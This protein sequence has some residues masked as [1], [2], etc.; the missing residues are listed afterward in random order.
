V[1]TAP[2]GPFVTQVVKTDAN[3]IFTYAMPA[4]GWWGFA[5]L[6]EDDRTMRNPED[7]N[8]YPVEIGALIWVHVQDME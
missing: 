5:A 2:A 6:N 4:A 7:N 3:G 1:Y 8:D